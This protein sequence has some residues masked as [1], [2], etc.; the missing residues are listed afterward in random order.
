MATAESVKIKIQALINKGN[1]VTGKDSADLSSV[2]DELIEGYSEVLVDV[3][4]LPT[5][6]I[7]QSK[8]YRVTKDGSAELYVV[9]EGMSYPFAELMR[10]EGIECQTNYYVVNELPETM[11]PSAVDFTV[12][13]FYV[14]ES[15]GVCYF[16]PEAEGK[17]YTIGTY[18]FDGAFPDKGW[19]EDVSTIDEAGFYVVKGAGETTYGIPDE[20]KKL[21][22]FK[23]GVETKTFTVDD[24][25]PRYTPAF[26][27]GLPIAYAKVSDI[28]FDDLTEYLKDEYTLEVVSSPM[29][30]TE[31]SLSS[32]EYFED[33][34]CYCA[35]DFF[36][37]LNDDSVLGF[38]TTGVFVLVEAEGEPCEVNVT[39]PIFTGEWVEV[40]AGGGDADG[41][42][43]TVNTSAEMDAILGSAND[44]TVGTFY[45]YTG[46]TT[47]KYTNNT[48]Y[49]VGKKEG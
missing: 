31:L 23:G 14:L 26:A 3:D 24:T 12:F 7:D 39:L 35:T 11:E 8:I 28:I 22:V 17:V 45:Y 34:K 20:T 48:L 41:K 43:I 47:E 13:N 44:D 16:Y 32:M 4:A 10:L 30:S 27:A 33:L 29:G 6:N 42:P 25:F 40:G 36:F 2:V 1:T 9:G 49:A 38:G 46:E 19:A 37:V 18:M 15:T 5:E 21:Y